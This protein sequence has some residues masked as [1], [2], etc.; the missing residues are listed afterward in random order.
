LLP[1]TPIVRDSLSAIASDPPS[2]AS[3]T[4]GYKAF[5]ADSL[6]AMYGAGPQ[7]AQTHG[8]S[9]R[10]Y[11]GA[12]TSLPPSP[13]SATSSQKSVFEYRGHR[14]TR[15]ALDLVRRQEALAQADSSGQYAGEVSWDDLRN[16]WIPKWAA[17]LTPCD[18]ADDGLPD[19]NPASYRERTTDDWG[20][21]I[22]WYEGRM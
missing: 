12:L 8:I 21:K 19:T 15:S 3:P 14:L 22:G 20:N 7:S 5:S 18:V 17:K 16:A 13:A 1:D 2:S 6:T 4:P 10:P 9:D 11:A